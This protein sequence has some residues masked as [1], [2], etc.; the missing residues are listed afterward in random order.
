MELHRCWSQTS[1]QMQKLRDNPECAQEEFD[2]L[3]DEEDPGLHADLSFDPADNPAAQYIATGARPRVAILR[4]QGVNSQMEMASAFEHAG[5]E[6]VDVHMSDILSGRRSLEEFHG[7]AACGGFSYGDV[8]GAGEGW[9]KSILFNDLARRLF[10]DYFQ[11]SDTFALGACNGC[12]MLSALKELIPGAELWPRFV[13]N[14]SEQFEARLSLVEVRESP[15]LLL[16]GMAGSRM[17]VVVSHGEGRAEWPDRGRAGPGR[18]RGPG[19][20]GLRGQLWSAGNSLS[21]QSERITGRCGRADHN[22]RSG[23]DHDAAPGADPAHGAEFLA[24]ATMGRRRAL[25]ADVP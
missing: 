15:S 21:C 19:K 1:Y 25:D 6:P 12:Q 16:T 7:L 22:R 3:L 13:R 9:A 23:D 5:F 8:L 20:C 11:R 24:P 17:P 18:Q 10:S 14:R 2:G 4:E